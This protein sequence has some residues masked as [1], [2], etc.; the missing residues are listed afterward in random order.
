MNPHIIKLLIKGHEE[1]IRE[2]DMLNWHLGMYVMHALDAT[3]CNAEFW[4]KKG[5]KPHSY[6]KQPFLYERQLEEDK[7]EISEEKKKEMENYKL[8]MSLRI[9]QANFEIN[10]KKQHMTMATNK[11]LP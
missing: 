5:S 3:V 8:A 11:G 2:Q 9:M 6:I 7:E 10:K 1:K 4:R